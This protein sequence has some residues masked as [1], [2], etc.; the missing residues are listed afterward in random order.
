MVVVEGEVEVTETSA[1]VWEVPQAAAEASEA[2]ETLEV[3]QE[4]AMATSD[5]VILG[6]V[7]SWTSSMWTTHRGGRGTMVG[8]HAL[9]GA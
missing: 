5:M 4:A 9:P 1:M 7:S 3:L 2:S 6:H 8:R